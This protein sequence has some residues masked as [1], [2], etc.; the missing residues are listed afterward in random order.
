MKKFAFFT[1]QDLVETVVE[2][3]KE[4][5]FEVNAEIVFSEERDQEYV[6]V[7]SDHETEE[8]L[9]EDL[10]DTLSIYLK[11]PFID[12]DE[13]EVGDFGTGFLFFY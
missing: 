5:G 2:L 3:Y 10:Q 13:M 9:L 6:V 1:R 12:Y 11:I 4:K 8:I 7:T